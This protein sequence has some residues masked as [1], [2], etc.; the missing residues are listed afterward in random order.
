[1]DRPRTGQS[2]GLVIAAHMLNHRGEIGLKFDGQL[3]DL[4]NSRLKGIEARPYRGNV[5]RGRIASSRMLYLTREHCEKVPRLPAECHRQRFQ[6]SRATTTPDSVPLNFPDDRNR[7]VRTL[8]ELALIPAEF[9]HAVAD[10]L[11]D[12]SPVFRHAFRHAST[13]ALRF[14][15]R[16]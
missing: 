13:S 11:S 9:A 2:R 14:Q 16:G 7:H 4:V 10:R 6:S 15:R 12:R 1:M 5:D 8:R 3:E